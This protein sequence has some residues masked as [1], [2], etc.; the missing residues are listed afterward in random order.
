MTELSD[1]DG[2]ADELGA[3]LAQR[4]GEKDLTYEQVTYI[5]SKLIGSIMLQ[6]FHN[7]VRAELADLQ[8]PQ[9]KS[10]GNHYQ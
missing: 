4:V 8:P 9:P 1:L 5:F 2:V 10:G 6:T 3:L 7:I